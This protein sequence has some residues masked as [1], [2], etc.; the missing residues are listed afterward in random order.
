[1]PLR[2]ELIKSFILDKFQLTDKEVLG[3]QRN[4]REEFFDVAFRGPGPFTEFLERCKIVE[5]GPFRVDSLEHRNHRVVIVN[6]FDMNLPDQSVGRFLE[7][8]ARV[9][10]GPR[11][12]RD[13]YGFWTG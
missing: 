2:E 12:R 3:I 13:I 7:R 11:Y 10:S 9:V 5:L 8:Y 1:M 6:M 4:N